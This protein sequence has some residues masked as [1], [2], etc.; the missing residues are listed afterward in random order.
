MANDTP[1]KE[2]RK[3]G[4]PVGSKKKK[5]K[6][7][8]NAT[9]ADEAFGEAFRNVP[10]IENIVEVIDSTGEKELIM[11]IQIWKRLRDLGWSYFLL[12]MKKMRDLMMIMEAERE[13]KQLLMM[14]LMIMLD[15]DQPIFMM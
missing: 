12:D 7:R 5:K 14:K 10:T 8:N 11:L 3:R 1:L 13:K 6:R 2:P 4:R 9:E 15:F